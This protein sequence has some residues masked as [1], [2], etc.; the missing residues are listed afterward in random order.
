MISFLIG[1]MPAPL[2]ILPSRYPIYSKDKQGLIII[3]HLSSPRVR[4]WGLNEIHF[5]PLPDGVSNVQVCETSRAKEIVPVERAAHPAALNVLEKAD[6]VMGPVGHG[7][8]EL[9]CLLGATLAPCRHQKLREGSSK[10]YSSRMCDRDEIDSNTF[11]I[12]C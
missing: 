7:Q 1:W 11:W 8:G 12:V 10:E 2:Y 9:E 6:V 4:F 5:V 3:T